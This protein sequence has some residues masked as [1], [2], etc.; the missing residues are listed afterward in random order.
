MINHEQYFCKKGHKNTSENTGKNGRCLTCANTYMAKYRKER[1]ETLNA[2]TRSYYRAHK[3]K[4]LDYRHKYYQDHKEELR[5]YRAARK[6]KERLGH[7]RR[8][9]GLSE[10]QYKT[11]LQKQNNQCPCGTTFGTKRETWPYVDHD[12]ACCPTEKSCGKCVRGILCNR[13]NTVLG[14]MKE[15]PKLLPQFLI[16]YLSAVRKTDDGGPA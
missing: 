10:E 7:C 2:A 12:H 5:Q 11:M 3:K 9:Y 14:L 15:D 13:C 8:K 6:G 1:K 16:N 4:Q